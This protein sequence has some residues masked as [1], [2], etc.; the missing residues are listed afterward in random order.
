M[1]GIMFNTLERCI[2]CL[3]N[4]RVYGKDCDYITG[5]NADHKNGLC[6]LHNVIH[7]DVAHYNESYCDFCEMDLEEK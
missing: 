7:C 6:E 5:E 3:E 2:D 4:E 1:G